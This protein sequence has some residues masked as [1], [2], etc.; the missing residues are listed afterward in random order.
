MLLV[1]CKKGIKFSEAG[2]KVHTVFVLVGTKD[3][4]NFHLRVLAAIAQIVQS[5][6][7]NKKWLAAK[8][9]QSLKDII[10]LGKRLR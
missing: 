3:E 9:K 8:N 5:D 1:R 2:K 10:L 7:F 6:N 4:R